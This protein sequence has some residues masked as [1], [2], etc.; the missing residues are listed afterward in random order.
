MN[1]LRN[2]QTLCT[3]VAGVL[4][5]LQEN[6]N[7]QAHLLEGAATILPQFP[8]QPVRPTDP[9]ES[10]GRTILDL[11]PLRPPSSQMY[12]G[13]EEGRRAREI[14]RLND[15]DQHPNVPV[16]LQIPEDTT[17]LTSSFFTGLFQPSLQRLDVEGFQK[18]YMWS[19]Y[20]R[21]PYDVHVLMHT[22]SR[23]D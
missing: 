15:H 14:L 2:P 8:Q 5:G 22:L 12:T 21:W 6:E 18:K 7:I 4:F 9:P 17:I 13:V 11:G 1:P 3:F 16:V 19:G 10:H 23:V 20:T